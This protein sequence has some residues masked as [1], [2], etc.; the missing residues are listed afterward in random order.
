MSSTL[1]ELTV[2]RPTTE[3]LIKAIDS[4]KTAEPRIAAILGATFLEDVTH[5]AILTKTVDLSKS[6]DDRLFVGSAPLSSFSAK[7]TV[8]FALGLIGPMARHDLDR[9]R[10]IRNAFAHAKIDISFDTPAIVNIV[11]GLHFRALASEWGTLNTQQKFSIVV[12]LLQIYL[13]GTWSPSGAE[14]KVIRDF[15]PPLPLRQVPSE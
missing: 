1:K 3:D 10:E 4:I 7:I 5:L 12:R 8:A 11:E 13:I 9:I 15:D 14:M 6:D 2:Q